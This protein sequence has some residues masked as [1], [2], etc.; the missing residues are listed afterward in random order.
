MIIQSSGTK[1]A[2]GNARSAKASACGNPGRS[3][4]GNANLKLRMVMCHPL[5]F[6]EE[7]NREKP[8][9]GAVYFAQAVGVLIAHG[10]L[11]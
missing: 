8:P 2:A 5:A 7:Q 6:H 9:A 10:P 11:R 3:P 4:V 1:E